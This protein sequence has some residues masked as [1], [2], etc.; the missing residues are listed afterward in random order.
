MREPDRLEDIGAYNARSLST[1]SR[2][3]T[4][5]NG[6]FALI[7]VR[8][9]YEVCSW[10][11]WQRLEELTAIPLSKLVLQTSIKTLLT[12]ILT[13]ITVEQTS[14]LVVFGLE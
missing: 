14:A 10:Q 13:D 5:S 2:A 1:L 8:C 11:M 4:L 7:L 6:Q 12:S 3:I 9:N